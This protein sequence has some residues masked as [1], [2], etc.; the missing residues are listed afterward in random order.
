MDFEQ[1]AII[2]FLF[3]EGI[4]ANDIHRRLSAQFVDA[5]Y[6]LRS[7]QRWCQYVGQGRE[8]MHDEPRSE[9]PSVD[10]LEI[11]ILSGL[12]KLPFHSAYSLAEIRKVPHTIILNHLQDTLGMKHFHL[13]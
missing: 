13:R 12:E 3:K 2:R 7:V 11:Q 5:A 9:S 8:L 10:F 1:R 6:S 4:D